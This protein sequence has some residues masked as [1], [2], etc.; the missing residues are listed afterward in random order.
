M[1]TG[2]VE[3]KGTLKKKER[4]GGDCRLHIE[5]PGLDL[6]S[7]RPGDSISVS[8]ACLTMLEPGGSGFYAD[9]SQETLSLT[10]LGQLEHGQEVNLEL[11]MGVDAR[12]GGHLV[13]GHAGQLEAGPERFGDELVAVTDAAHCPQRVSLP[14]WRKPDGQRGGW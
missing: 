14:R 2:I 3:N 9:V 7:A 6:S 4:L 1:F 8:G 11:A 5:C 10:T 13:T 12:L